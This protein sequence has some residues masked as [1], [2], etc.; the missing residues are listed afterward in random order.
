[1]ANRRTKATEVEQ[2]YI[3]INPDGLSQEALSQKFELTLKTVSTIQQK[4]NEKQAQQQPQTSEPKE[5][6]PGREAMTFKINKNKP[7]K[8]TIMTEAASQ[9]AEEAAKNSRMNKKKN[10]YDNNYTTKSFPED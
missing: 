10:K 9:I 2:L 1:M 5:K 8:V 7:A 4:Y 3:E 6:S